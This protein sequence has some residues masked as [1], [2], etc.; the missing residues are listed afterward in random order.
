M[1][2]GGGPVP[3]QLTGDPAHGGQTL[4]GRRAANTVLQNTWE[5]EERDTKKEGGDGQIQ[6]TESE[7]V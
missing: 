1:P 4:E 6:N 7:E 5:T 3:G 2:Q